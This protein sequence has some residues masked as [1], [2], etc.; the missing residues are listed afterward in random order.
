MYAA[1]SPLNARNIGQ[2]ASVH[3]TL[4]HDGGMFTS[5]RGQAGPAD[6]LQ[7]FLESIW[8]PANCGRLSVKIAHGTG[9]SKA[10]EWRNLMAPYPVALVV[11]WNLWS[12]S[13]DAEAP[14]PSGRTNL[15][16]TLEK[17]SETLRKRREK[18]AQR[19]ADQ[20]NDSE[21][22]FD[23]DSDGPGARKAPSRNY[24]DHYRNVVR[25]CAGHRILGSR[26]ISVNDV[27]RAVDL[28][29]DA[30]TSWARMGCHLT[31]NFHG[32]VHIPDWVS[33]WGPLYSWWAWPFERMNGILARVKTNGH[34][35]GELEATMMRA[36]VKTALAQDLVCLDCSL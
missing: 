11:A 35:G 20:D 10:D 26:A 2:A 36:W 3:K 34:T 13:E 21:P 25:F 31:P 7:T 29:C 28:H 5:L 27:D 4:L 18:N 6:V 8:W 14:L 12:K 22:D 32:S 30:F 24:W 16:K 23:S 9:R 33:A 17:T 15:A 19:T 1:C